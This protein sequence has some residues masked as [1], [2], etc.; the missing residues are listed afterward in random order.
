MVKW[1]KFLASLRTIFPELEDEEGRVLQSIL[2]NSNTGQVNQHK[3]SEF[4]KGFGPIQDC[5]KNVPISSAHS[6]QFPGSKHHECKMVL[7]L[8]FKT[9]IRV[10]FTRPT[11]WHLSHS[12]QFFPTWF[13]CLSLYRSQSWRKIHFSHFNQLLQTFWLSS[14]RKSIYKAFQSLIRSCRILFRVFTTSLH[15]R[16]AL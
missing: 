14:P 3:F 11:S 9:R 6:S 12:I 10:T 8:S 7:W 2:D 13:F 5:L 1:D 16:I 15:F 4:L